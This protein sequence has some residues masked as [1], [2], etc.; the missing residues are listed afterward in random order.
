MRPFLDSPTQRN[1]GATKHPRHTLHI[2]AALRGR[3][4]MCRCD[5]MRAF[6][7]VR[8]VAHGVVQ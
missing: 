4:A 3:Y 8:Q 1:V 5:S 7:D 6:G 2:Q